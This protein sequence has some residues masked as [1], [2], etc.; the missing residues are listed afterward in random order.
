LGWWY[1]RAG[2]FDRAAEL[3]AGAVQE[4]PADARMQTQLAWALVEQR[5][6]ESAIQRF[7]SVIYQDRTPVNSD[8][9]RHSRI[10]N[11]AH[12]GLAVAYRQ[13]QVVE[14]SKNEFSGASRSQPEW[15][16]PKWVAALY[17]PG[18]AKTIEELKAE[19]RAPQR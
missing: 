8:W 6:L 16:N 15:L 3:M 5:N 2:K 14:L 18:V 4:R 9:K 19:Q 17:S 12:I 1:Y 11:E 13:S 7:H 10:I